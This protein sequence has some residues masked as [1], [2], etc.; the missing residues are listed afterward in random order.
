M[1]NKKI[2]T[3]IYITEKQQ[4]Q[5]KELNDRLKVPVSELIR[6]GIDLI[7]KKYDENLSGQISLFE[8]IE[9]EKK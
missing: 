9:S 1:S 2:A 5:L 4:D 7:V 8:E 3:T 6:Q